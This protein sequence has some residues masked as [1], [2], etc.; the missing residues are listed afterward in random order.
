M[1]KLIWLYLPLKTLLYYSLQHVRVK[2]PHE[3]NTT[4]MQNY[5]KCKADRCAVTYP[6]FHGDVVDVKHAILYIINSNPSSCCE[7]VP[8]NIR[9]SQSFFINKDRLPCEN[10]WH[11]DEMPW[12]KQKGAIIRKYHVKGTTMVWPK[13]SLDADQVVKVTKNIWV[14]AHVN[15][16]RK[17]AISIEGNPV[18]FIQY[19]GFNNQPELKLGNRRIRP[20]TAQLIDSEILST[21]STKRIVH[22]VREKVAAVKG[23]PSSTPSYRSVTWQKEKLKKDEVKDTLISICHKMAEEEEEHKYIRSYQ[24]NANVVS[25]VG[26]DDQQLDDIEHFYCHEGFPCSPLYVDTAFKFGKIFVVTTS[27]RHLQLKNKDGKH[28]CLMGPI[29]I[30]HINLPEK[31]TGGYSTKLRKLALPWL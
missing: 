28:P 13:R 24:V 20:S 29:M 15:S 27:Y 7:E 30:T 6:H 21:K 10:D 3:L 22:N 8:I 2:N 5:V 16:A 12:T 17:V 25:V 31:H 11:C 1:V 26:F 23:G 19:E 9:N 4:T 18:V 14:H